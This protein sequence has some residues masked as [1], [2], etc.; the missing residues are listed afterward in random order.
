MAAPATGSIPPTGT[1][2]LAAPQSRSQV[3]QNG[4]SLT[5]EGSIDSPIIFADATGR[6]TLVDLAKAP[7]KIDYFA[8]SLPT[9]LLFEDDLTRRQQTT[10]LFFQ[11]QAALG[12]GLKSKAKQLVA[13]VLARDPS[14]AG[15]ADLMKDNLC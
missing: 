7:A 14:H 8:T 11:A 13:K 10:A 1:Y 2:P 6:I 9:M 5:V 4:G 15:A 3:I 12:L